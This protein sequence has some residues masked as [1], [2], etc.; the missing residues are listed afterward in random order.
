MNHEETIFEQALGIASADGR[1]DYLRHACEGN[2]ALFQ[3][4][5]ALLRAH[6]RAGK[7]LEHDKVDGEQL[8][9]ADPTS[10]ST[11]TLN[12]PVTEKPGDRIGRYKLLQKIGEGGCGVV[13]MAE[14]EEPVRRRVALKIIKLG[15]DTRQVIARF[16][17]ERQALAL[18]EHPNIAKVF[19][20]GV[21]ETTLSQENTQLQRSRYA[22]ATTPIHEHRPLGP[23]RPY[24]VM[25]LVRGVKI[26]EYCDEKKL[27]TRER[28]ELFMQVCRAVQHAHQKGIIHRDLKPSNILVSVDDGIAVPKVIDFGIAK[29][30]SG[31]PLTD[32]TV[33]TAFEQFIGTPA[34]MSPEQALVTSLD[35]DTRTDIYSLGVLLYELLTGQTPFDAKELLQ[36][37]LDE[38]RRTIR[39]K[40]PERPSTRL[41]TIPDEQLSTTA[42]RRGLDA[43]KLVSQLRGDLDWIIMKCL[44]KDRT[45][46]YETAAG[47]AAD[48]HRYLNNEPVVARPP[49]N[50][51][52][53]QKMVRRNRLAF[54]ASAS[55]VVTLL[56]GLSLSTYMFLRERAA[57]HRAFLGERKAETEAANSAREAQRARRAESDATEKLWASYLAQAQARRWSGRVGR[58]VGALEAL[59]RAS[60]IRPAL[61]LR[62]EAIA[63]LALLDL[64]SMKEWDPFP[65][66]VLSSRFDAN[67]QSY[68]CTHT[69]G[70]VNVRRL[71]DDE[72]LARLPAF[73]PL[74][75]GMEFS[76]DGRFFVAY[77]GPEHHLRVWHLENA[78]AVFN[79]TNEAVRDVTFSPD[80]RLLA[81][82]TFT[83]P[84]FPLRIYDRVNWQIRKSIEAGT[85]SCEM[86]FHPTQ[87][88]L[89]AYCDNGRSVR[90]WD[91]VSDKV[92]LTLEHPGSVMDVCW[93]TDGRWLATACADNRVHLWEF[94]TGNK[95]AVLEGHSSAVVQLS[96]NRDASLLLSRSWDGTLRLWDTG[97]HRELLALQVP[98]LVESF[99]QTSDQIGYI[100][101]HGRL[102]IFEV[103][104]PSGYRVLRAREK[105]DAR[106]INCA[107]SRDG[108]ILASSHQEHVRF[109]DVA[110]GRQLAF[111]AGMLGSLAFHPKDREFFARTPTGVQQWKLQAADDQNVVALNPGRQFKIL[112][113]QVL[114]DS[115]GTLLGGLSHA[116]GIFDLLDLTTGEIRAQFNMPYSPGFAALSP[117]G[118]LAAHWPRGPANQVAIFDIGSTQSIAQLPVGKGCWAAFSPNN[119]W[120]ATGDS[121]EVRL[122]ERANWKT[123]WTARRQF[124]DF[125]VALAFSEDSSMLA[126]AHSRDVVRVFEAATGRELAT[127]EAPE[128]QDII[129]LAFNPDGTQLAV[130][131]DHGPIHLWDLRLIRQQ[132]ARMNLDWELPPYPPATLPA[133]GPVTVSLQ[134]EATFPLRDP[135]LSPKLIDLSAHYNSRLNKIR[136]NTLFHLT[137]NFSTFPRGVVTLGGTQFDIR[138]IVQLLGSENEKRNE[139]VPRACREIRVTQTCHALQFLHATRYGEQIDAGTLI[140]QYILHYSDGLE[141]V[142]PIKYGEDLRSWWRLPNQPETATRAQIAW[143]DDN[144]LGPM[145]LFKLTVE[146]PR[147][148]ATVETIDFLS[149]MTAAAPLLVAIT[150]E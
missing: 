76:P 68:A 56:F 82:A 2:T 4:L 121:T 127:L 47:L 14:Q 137:N 40:E 120:L 115:A 74:L 39:E 75:D 59:R 95:I 5:Q 86:R 118:R 57:T 101:S 123:L 94:P 19:D 71:K 11:L 20:A 108:R 131:S 25:E 104:H 3:R 140:G 9:A 124:T 42:Q 138:G 66:A 142:I 133:S 29:A 73:S 116:N 8:P 7:F 99:N 122:W 12:V 17:A 130:V 87:S 97:S 93:D 105:E 13:Y 64:H 51:Y 58:R 77:G 50:F 26:T 80:S 128:P 30:T 106:T 60:G 81:V 143:R 141:H 107:F 33:F 18:M 91:W 103:V 145:R 65:G 63:C 146:N 149:A 98:G 1:D 96:F 139:P 110:T 46:R 27:T 102:G 79:I 15:M 150:V 78:Q 114:I 24:F 22:Y 148:T 132:L 36:S 144:P 147:L 61:E 55:L 49:S 72:E 53:F 38:M 119:R 117:D 90:L 52:R 35:I 125:W 34:Y 54:A 84:T 126:V 31:E 135:M 43:P 69:N 10:G 113:E 62:N 136:R 28:L 67:Y 41:S 134:A 89:L 44:E 23:G 37:G 88:N 109:W 92:V 32:K 48:L 70:T 129:S 100:A 6:Y 83:G 16:E 21:T 111:Q 45:R 112:P 85:L